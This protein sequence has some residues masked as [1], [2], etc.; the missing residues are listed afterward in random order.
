LFAD[1]GSSRRRFVGI[2]G[3]LKKK[4]SSRSLNKEGRK[5]ERERE[6]ERGEEKESE[7]ERERKRES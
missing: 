7:R 6:R 4:I 1:S 5:R 2:A 3:E